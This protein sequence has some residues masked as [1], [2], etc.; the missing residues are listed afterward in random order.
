MKNN[1]TEMLAGVKINV[2]GVIRNTTELS[3]TVAGVI[4]TVTEE[5]SIVKILLNSDQIP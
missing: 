2:P 3:R 1:K 5:T 4:R